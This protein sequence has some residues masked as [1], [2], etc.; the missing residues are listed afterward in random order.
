M[1]QPFF[2][3]R[4]EYRHREI[5]D[6]QGNERHLLCEK[7]LVIN[8]A[9]SVSS[10]FVKHKLC[11]P[12][13]VTEESSFSLSQDFFL[14]KIRKQIV[15]SGKQYVLM[16]KIACFLTIKLIRSKK[17]LQTFIY[18][19][20]FKRVTAWIWKVFSL[21]ALDS[22]DSWGGNEQYFFAMADSQ[23]SQSP[24]AAVVELVARDLFVIT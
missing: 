24:C 8:S 10:S 21:V 13:K 14:L 2:M 17:I 15:F 4:L 12:H 16:L 1:E 11:R 22:A 5:K 23:S 19:L 18:N 6:E 3:F 7:C 9:R 20:Y